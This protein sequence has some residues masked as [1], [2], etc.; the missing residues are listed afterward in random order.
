[1]V[2]TLAALATITLVNARRHHA[3]QQEFLASLTHQARAVESKTPYM[4]GHAERVA[5]LSVLLARRLQVPTELIAD[6]RAG[7]LLHEIGKIGVAESIL[8][9][10]GQLTDAEFEALKQYPLI[11]YTICEPLGLSPDVLLLVRNHAERLDGTG[12]PDNLKWGELPLSLRI[13]GVADAFDAMS[14]YR[15]WRKGMNSRT[16]REELNRFAGTQFDPVVVEALKDLL[17]E[18]ELDA[19]YQ[20]HWTPDEPE[21]FLLQAA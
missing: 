9:K 11:G 17:G 4:Q 19:L 8:S 7:A 2:E 13:L 21:L 10:P 16:R 14:S 15:P 6:L 20:G 3:Q 1:M 12:Y 18:G 5:T